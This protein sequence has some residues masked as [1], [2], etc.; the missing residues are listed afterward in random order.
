MSGKFLQGAVSRGLREA[1]AVL[2]DETTIFS[3]HRPKMTFLGLTPFVT[4]D[5]F[6]A[7]S[8][9][10]IGEV[11]NWD[12]S[13]VWYGAVVRADSSHP[14]T[15]GF[16]SS[17]GE[18]SVVTTLRKNG[19]LKTGFPP[20]CHIG[21]YVTVGAGSVLKSCRIDDLVVIG[22]KC[23]IMEGALVEA[24][25][26][27]EP[28]TVVPAY[29]RIPA[30][31]KWGGN[32]AKFVA[33]LTHDEVEDIKRTSTEIHQRAKEHILEFLPVGNTYVHLEELERQQKDVKQG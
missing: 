2:R 28:G 26:M 16:N 9:S 12:Q 15:I 11:T 10:I 22:E 33:N 3:R 31:Q 1:G 13:S 25:V 27:L 18:G 20:V 29:A 8:A 23:T 17:I 30:G 32:P 6:I 19:S 21:H 24:N 5:T 14:I 4:N 7:P